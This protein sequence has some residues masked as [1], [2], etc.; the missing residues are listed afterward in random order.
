MA[1]H[2]KKYKKHLKKLIEIKN[3][4]PWKQSPWPRNFPMPNLMKLWKS[5]YGWEST[6]ATLTRSFATW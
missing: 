2:G 3:I 4:P 6:P 5:M 1:K